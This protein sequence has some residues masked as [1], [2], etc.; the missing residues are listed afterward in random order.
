MRAIQAGK[1]AHLPAAVQASCG[2]PS[3]PQSRGAV[4]RLFYF[5]RGGREVANLS[6]ITEWNSPQGLLLLQRYAMYGMTQKEICDAIGVPERTFRR[7]CHQDPRIKQA[8][9][10]GGDVAVAAVANALFKKAQNGDLGAICFFLKNRDPA[11][12]SDHPEMRGQDGKV[13]FVDDIPAANPAAQPP[14]GSQADQPDHT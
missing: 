5:E 2:W 10:S 7:W 9:S 14:A 13:V 1:R 3:K 4:H 8:I 12:W 11:H 6:K